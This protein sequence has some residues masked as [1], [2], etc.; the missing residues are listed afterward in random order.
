MTTIEEIKNVFEEMWQDFTGNMAVGEFYCRTE[1]GTIDEY[2]KTL[3]TAIRSLEAWKKVKEE[4][5]LEISD[6]KALNFEFTIM[7]LE[8]VLDIIDKHLK[9]VESETDN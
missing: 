5:N 7:V 1:D 9:E 3:D 8:K 6:Y 2:R 4:I